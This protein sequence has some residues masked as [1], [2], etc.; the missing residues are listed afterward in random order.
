MQQD[1]R[2]LMVSIRC[3]AYNQARYIRQTLE[4][5]VMQKTSFRFEAAVH[6]DAST[7]GTADIIREYAERYPDIIKPILEKENQFSKKDGSLGRI[8][9]EACKGKYVA[10]CEGDDYWI[11]PYKLQKQVDILESNPSVTLVHTAFKNV[12]Q[13]DQEII[14]EGYENMMRLSRSGNVL[15]GLFQGNYIL[16]LTTCM[17]REV[18]TS[19]LFQESPVSLDYSVFMTA[20]SMGDIYY[21]PD[22]T[23]CYRL[24]PNGMM[25]RMENAVDEY[26]KQ[27]RLYFGTKVIRGEINRLSPLQYHSLEKSL[28]HEA[29]VWYRVKNDSRYIKSI[30]KE[31]PLLAFHL[32]N[33]LIRAKLHTAKSCAMTGA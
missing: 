30:L 25:H 22:V 33:H 32:I 3:V 16:T 28:I 8:M 9:N 27:I 15:Y 17:R 12:D 11:D 21:L 14:R 7:D 6:D 13:N 29:Y 24:N 31:K 4:G 23:G 10:Y 20:A 19:A 5:F 18:F 26:I 2:P 1:Q